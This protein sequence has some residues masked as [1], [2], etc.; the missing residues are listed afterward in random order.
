M[1]TE[2]QIES[3][4]AM[5]GAGM[6]RGQIENFIRFEYQPFPALMQFHVAARACDVQR[7][8]VIVGMGGTRGPGKSHATMAQ[9]SLDDCQRAPGLKVLFL[10]RV[11]KSAAESLEDLIGRVLRK[12]DHEYKA[13]IGRIDFPNGSRVL[14]GGF[15]SERDIDRYLGIEYDAVA[16]EEAT[17]LPEERINQIR[18]SV[19]TSRDDWRP[20][21]Y[22]T[23]NPDGV[24]LAWFKRWL[25]EPWR[26]ARE[27]HTRFIQAS[28]K[29]NPVLNREYLDYLDGLTGPL[30]RAWRDGDWDAFEGQA[31]P[32]WRYETHV[33]EPFEIPEHWLK[34]RAVDEGYANPW[35][36]LWMAQDPATKRRYVYREAYATQLTARQQAERILA[37]TGVEEVIFT[38]FADP[39]L[40][41]RKNVDNIVKTTAMEYAE[42]GVPLTKADNDRIQGKRRVDS[43][44]AIGMDGLPG[45]QVFSTCVNLI[46]TLPMMVYD[47][48]RVEDVDT[49][50]EDHAYDTLKYGLS[51]MRM[52]VEEDGEKIKREA[53]QR[54]LQKLWEFM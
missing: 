39:A 33:V 11:Q 44:L 28:Y 41:G 51:N 22:L 37:M 20:R 21:V 2:V 54:V 16:I 7:G 46:R 27:I 14:L 30:R 17:Q 45:L 47:A 10:R 3:V 24:G 40:W 53:E 26:D 18:G 52:A 9:V 36:C 43:A 1:L 25:V 48:V 38:T 15:H 42:A 23:A 35:C 32:T 34:W 49:D 13:S 4:N 8:P 31:F 50:G 6:P 29:D 12:C 19:R 5:A